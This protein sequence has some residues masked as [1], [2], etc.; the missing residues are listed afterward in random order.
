LVTFQGTL[1]L[2]IYTDHLKFNIYMISLHKYAGSKQSYAIMKFLI[3]V[4]LAKA[5]HVIEGIK[6]K[7]GD[8]QAYDRSIVYAVVIT[9]TVYKLQHI[10]AVQ[11]WTADLR[12]H[13]KKTYRIDIPRINLV[14]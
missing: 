2:A 5:R 13:K 3:F 12:I 7:R 14:T 10:S 4:L 11:I 6:T 1:R 9:L 8:G